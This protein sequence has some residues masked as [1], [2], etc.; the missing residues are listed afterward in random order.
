MKPILWRLRN[1]LQ[2]FDTYK[3]RFSKGDLSSLIPPAVGKNSVEMTRHSDYGGA[4][5]MATEKSFSEIGVLL[6]Y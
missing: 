2:K 6:K 5:F 1:L 4:F 3:I